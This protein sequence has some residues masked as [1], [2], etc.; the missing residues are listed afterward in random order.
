MRPRLEYGE[1]IYD[2]FYNSSILRKV[3]KNACLAIAGVNTDTSTKKLYH[4]KK[5]VRPPTA[6]TLVQETGLLF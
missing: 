6:P 3:E 2:Q 4:D 5:S 1:I